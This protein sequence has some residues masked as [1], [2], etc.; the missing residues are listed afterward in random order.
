MKSRDTVFDFK[1]YKE[2]LSFKLE[3]RAALEK[4][5]RI[6]LAAK[7]NCKPSFI[8][9]VLSGPLDLSPEHAQSANEFLGHSNAEAKFFLALVLHAR[10]GTPSLRKHYQEEIQVLRGEHLLVINRV[11]FKRTL[12]EMEQARYYSAWHYAA[13][14]VLVSINRL[15]TAEKIAVALSL[16]LRTVNETVEFLVEIGL[17]N[18]RDGELSQGETSLFLGA[19]SPYIA[20]HHLNWRLQAIRS[21]DR[22]QDI[23]LHYSGV[24]TLSREDVDRIREILVKAI[25]K[26]RQTVTQSKDETLYS[27][28]LD[29]FGLLPQP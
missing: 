9:Q 12:N 7:L 5:Q 25:Q 22:I 19:D 24:V 16:P 15:R 10:A 18:Q 2:Y 28:T 6:R 17:L 20:R 11:E 8:S 27:Y 26:V 4:G 21:L 1:D 23:D 14:H 29:F 3:E 13:I